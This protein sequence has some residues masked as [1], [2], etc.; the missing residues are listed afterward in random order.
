VDSLHFVE[1]LFDH[2]QDVG[3]FAKD[4]EGRFIMADQTFIRMLRCEEISQVLGKT[5]R[6][7]FPDHVA[8]KYIDDDLNV[9][10]RKEPLLHEIEVFPR[11]DFSLDWHEANKFPI[12]DQDGQ[13]IGIAG[14]TVK[15]SP[16]HMPWNYPP[17]LGKI[18]D[19]IGRFYGNKITIRQLAE[20]A[21]MSERSLERHFAKTFRTTPLRYLKRVRINAAC[22]A[23]THTVKPIS[24]IALEC[25][26]CDQ[27]HLT[28]EFRRVLS[29]TPREYRLKHSASSH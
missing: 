16:S 12:M 28:S 19:Y 1:Q 5:D 29:L 26:F 14:I 27:S 2:L 11:D 8:Q 25:G 7:F 24:E 21:N 20:I 23:L 3:Y 13:A 4:R 6:D 22:H 18:L 17:K 9:L 10:N 15:L